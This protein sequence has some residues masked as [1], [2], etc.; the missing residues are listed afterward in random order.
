M[1]QDRQPADVRRLVPAFGRQVRNEPF[2][3]GGTKQQESAVGSEGPEL[4]EAVLDETNKPSTWVGGEEG[5][6]TLGEIWAAEFDTCGTGLG[7]K[8]NLEVRDSNGPS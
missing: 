7:M 5:G 4:E 8:G 1:L 2:E 6:R 3:L